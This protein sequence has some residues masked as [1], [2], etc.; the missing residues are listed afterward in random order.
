[1]EVPYGK[2]KQIWPGYYPGDGTYSIN[3]APKQAEILKYQFTSEIPGFPKGEGEMVVSNLW[4]GKPNESDCLLGKNWYSDSSDP[5]K[6]DGK[7][8]G[9][10]TLLKWRNNI[11]AVWAKRW[12][13]LRK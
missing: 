2:N 9:G 10:K 12:E 6:Y 8:Q 7:L 1:M 3:Y 13:W 5:K 11:L 4:P